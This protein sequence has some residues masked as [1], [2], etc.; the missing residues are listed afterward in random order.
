MKIYKFDK[1]CLYSAK[2]RNSVP[3]SIKGIFS[4]DGYELMKKLK[5][6]IFIK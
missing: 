6:D 5:M 4:N 2:N 1:R 3:D